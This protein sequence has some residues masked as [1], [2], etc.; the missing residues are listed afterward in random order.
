[1]DFIRE[2]LGMTVSASKILFAVAFIALIFSNAEGVSLLP[3]PESPSQ[4]SSFVQLH[5]LSGT[6]N[7]TVKPGR[8]VKAKF[9][10]SDAI[11]PADTSPG[12][13]LTTTHFSVDAAPKVLRRPAD[14]LTTPDLSSRTTRGPPAS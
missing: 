6:Y 1:M 3:F 12:P 10:K 2:K 7:Q 11:H 8:T 13:G 4:S 9:G 5:E 14:I